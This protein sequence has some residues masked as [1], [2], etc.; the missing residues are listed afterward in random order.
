[1]I[2]V[3][4]G[5]SQY[6]DEKCRRCKKDL[7]RTNTE[8]LV[9]ERIEQIHKDLST[10]IQVLHSLIVS[11]S[12][13]KDIIIIP[14]CS[15]CGNLQGTFPSLQKSEDTLIRSV[16]EYCR[17]NVS[18]MSKILNSPKG[19]VYRKINLLGLLK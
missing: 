6:P 16:F 1:M 15:S 18:E 4:C 10:R 12:V 13:H 14:P 7:P 9:M 8:L 19:T 17:G 2:C 5:L 11:E 3:S